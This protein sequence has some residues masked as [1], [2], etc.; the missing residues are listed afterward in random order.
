[1]KKQNKC[2]NDMCLM[3]RISLVIFV[4]NPTQFFLKM[5]CWSVI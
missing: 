5:I 1:M 3:Y 2:F 4:N